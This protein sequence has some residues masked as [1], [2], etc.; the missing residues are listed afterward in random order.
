MRKL[1]YGS[2]Q[3]GMSQRNCTVRNKTQYST[4]Q[5]SLNPVGYVISEISRNNTKMESYR[6]S[7][8]IAVMSINML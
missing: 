3:Q 5:N 2:E 7:M 8:F 4:V 1:Q 6:S